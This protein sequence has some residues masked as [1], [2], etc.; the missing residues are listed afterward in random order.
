MLP[1]LYR[2]ALRNELTARAGYMERK[3]EAYVNI[4]SSGG[5]SSLIRSLRPV[6]FAP[7][8][9]GKVNSTDKCNPLVEKA[10]YVLNLFDLKDK[11]AKN[12]TIK[13]QFYL[14]ML[15]SAAAY[16]PRLALCHAALSDEATLSALRDALI[17]ARLS[18]ADLSLP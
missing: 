13:H 15:E 14:S 6:T 17:D 7:Y 2:Y 10:N 8:F 12:N 16:E 5:S 11:K 1:E 9:V 4:L 3:V 18:G